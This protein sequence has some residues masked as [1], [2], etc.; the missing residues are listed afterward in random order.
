MLDET[1][2]GSLTILSVVETQVGDV[3]TY[4]LINVISITNGQIFLETELFYCGI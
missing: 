1:S 4:I 2:A 3:F